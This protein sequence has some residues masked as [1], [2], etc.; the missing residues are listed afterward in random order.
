MPSHDDSLTSVLPAMT[1]LASLSTA[2]EVRHAISERRAGRDPAA[3]E[4]AAVARPFLHEA[5]AEL[6]ELLLRLR[7]GLAYIDEHQEE[8]DVAFVRHF[9]H[10]MTLNRTSRLLHVIHQRMLS[11]YPDVPED[12]PEEVRLLKRQCETLIAE[13]DKTAFPQHLRAFLSQAFTTT[14]R[15]RNDL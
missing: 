4:E 5:R 2:A 15:L 14:A 3:Q 10:L 8:A 12:L 6:L 11:L 9:D 1:L 7:T 13:E